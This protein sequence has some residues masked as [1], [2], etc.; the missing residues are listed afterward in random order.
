M[1]SGRLEEVDQPA[2]GTS[3]FV[4]HRCGR[5]V[6]TAPRA[7]VGD[8]AVSDSPSAPLSI[9]DPRLSSVVYVVRLQRVTPTAAPATSITCE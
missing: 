1:S 4:S 3:R 6:P 2:E 9:P 7:V 8:V 5:S